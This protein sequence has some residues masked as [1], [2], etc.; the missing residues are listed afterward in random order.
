M[1][2]QS[3]FLEDEEDLYRSATGTSSSGGRGK[4]E[5]N[6]LCSFFFWRE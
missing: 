3:F 5:L 4:V 1:E 6:T 2:L